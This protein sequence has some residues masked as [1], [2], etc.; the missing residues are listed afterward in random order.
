M[1]ELAGKGIKSVTVTVFHM[2]PK[3]SRETWKVKEKIQIKLLEMKTTMS[4]L[5]KNKNKKTLDEI[6]SRLDNAEKRFMN[7][8]TQQ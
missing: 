5:K 6:K 2:F 1:W 4:G 3:L 7:L 8:K